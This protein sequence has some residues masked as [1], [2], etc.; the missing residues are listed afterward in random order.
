MYDELW[1][2]EE[3]RKAI[4]QGDRLYVVSPATGDRTEVD[5]ESYD[6]LEDLP[7]CG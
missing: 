3:A 4:E 6:D 2:I 5:L 7:P 1:S